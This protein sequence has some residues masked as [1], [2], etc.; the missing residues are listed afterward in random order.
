MNNLPGGWGICAPALPEVLT[1]RTDNSTDFGVLNEIIKKRS[2]AMDTRY[3]WLMDR[4]RQKVFDVFWQPGRE[5]LGDYLT[6]HNSAQH[7]KDMRGLILHQANIL[8][9]LLGYVR[10]LVLPLPQPWLRTCQST[11]RATQLRGVLAHAY[12]V[13]WQNLNTVS[14][15]TVP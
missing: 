9:V 13:T 8:Q 1:L 10:L 7:H 5:N 11:Q 3:H 14:T 4:V 12:S 15:R 2:Q 6:K